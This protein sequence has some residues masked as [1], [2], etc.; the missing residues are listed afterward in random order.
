MPEYMQILAMLF[1]KLFIFKK[2]NI[3]NSLYFI[4]LPRRAAAR[5]GRPR[6]RGRGCLRGRVPVHPRGVL[7]RV[8]LRRRGVRRRARARAGEASGVRFGCS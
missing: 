4:R 2:M 8:A 5:D 3:S 1:Q 7:P 6:A